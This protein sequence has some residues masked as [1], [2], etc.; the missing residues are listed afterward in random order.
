MERKSS[1]KK[2]GG[3][4]ALTWIEPKTDWTKDDKFNITDYNRI[5]NNLLYLQELANQF[6]PPSK[7]ANLG[8]DK[9][10]YTEF[11]Y[12]D[13]FNAFEAHL[14][15]LNNQTLRLNIGRRQTF[16][17]NGVFIGFDELNRIERAQFDLYDNMR[18][19]RDGRRMHV[20]ALGMTEV[21][22]GKGIIAG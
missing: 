2:G 9:T 12:A 20:F 1:G 6:Y 14:D 3:F 4:V 18:N 8:A 7:T 19:Q 15:S 5:K 21:F 10:L 17:D 13:E 11:F 16:Y 22:N